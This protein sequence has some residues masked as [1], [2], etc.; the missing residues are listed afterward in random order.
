MMVRRARARWQWATRV[1]VLIALVAGFASFTT[2]EP[3][4]AATSLGTLTVDPGTGQDV[5]PIRVTTVSSAATKGCPAEATN[6]SGVITGP[7]GWAAGVIGAANTDAAIS[8]T[9]EFTVELQNSF[10]GI[11]IDNNLSVVAGKYTITIYCQDIFGNTKFGEFT[12]SLWFT[13]ST[14]Y[15]TTDPATST[16]TP[17]PTPT[18]TTPTATPTPTDTT[19]TSPTGTPTASETPTPTESST[20]TSTPT[21]TSEIPELGSLDIT[22][23][24][25][26]GTVND[27]IIVLTH[28]TGSPVGC[29]VLSQTAFLTMTGPGAWA[30]GFRVGGNSPVSEAQEIT[31]GFTGA[32]GQAAVENNAP[33]EAGKYVLA[34]KCSDEFGQAVYGQFTSP[35]WFVDSTH[36]QYSDPATSTATTT[37]VVTVTPVD[38]VEIGTTITLTAT[39]MQTNGVGSG[40]GKVQFRD[41]Q[42]GGFVPLGDPVALVN[43]VATINPS[44][45]PATPP[46]LYQLSA[47]FTPTDT[48]KQGA[49][50]SLDVTLAV[51]LPLPPVPK[52]KAATLGGTVRVGKT[53]T[54]AATFTGADSTT[55]RWWRD[56]VKQVGTASSYKLVTADG[57]HTIRCQVF[58]KNTG[59]TTTRMSKT[60]K[61]AK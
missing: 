41:H 32:V 20:P 10:S 47:A 33:F 49:S 34:V 51:V 46:V 30:S 9:S 42:N 59:G 57:G 22:A 1:T 40:V 26:G 54:C 44:S 56:R 12:G 35:L 6:T 17:T 23:P 28:S 58:A 55:Y 39:V 38:R 27:N 43:G 4:H 24:A 21:T 36:F 11:A 60:A 29:P 50:E 48:Q 14:H 61:V 8:H 3:V 19:T 7:G 5:D 18:T 53:V 25:G 31:S 37:T 16:P 15:Q 13:D 2:F 45:N 52:V